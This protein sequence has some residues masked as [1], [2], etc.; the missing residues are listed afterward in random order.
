M[1]ALRACLRWRGLATALLLAVL[2][3][4]AAASY[5]PP[6]PFHAEYE[7]NKGIL[8]LG[9]ASLSF[10]RPQ[11]GHYRY[12]L[13]MRPSGIAGWF[14][15]VTVREVSEGR[16]VDDGFRPLRYVYDRSGDDRARR[17]ELRFNWTT[18]TVVNDV[19]DTPWRMEVPDDALD[20]VVSPLQLMHDLAA[21]GADTGRLTYRI[22]DGGRLKTYTVSIEG[23]ETVDTPAGRFETV[24]VVRRDDEGERET[25]LWCAPALAYLAVKVEQW[26]ADD[27]TFE[28]VLTGVEGLPAD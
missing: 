6:P 17:A 19:G 25:R 28:L 15:D 12:R 4:S 5:E 20:R 8:T 23:T 13:F 14:T 1:N 26:E 7:L 16:I 27:G 11:P 2:A 24:K 9:S 10:S 3:P 18:G 22:A 21:R